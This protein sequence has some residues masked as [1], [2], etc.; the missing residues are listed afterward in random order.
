M[1]ILHELLIVITF[2]VLLLGTLFIFHTY[3]SH[4]KVI[5]K[6]KCK[7]GKHVFLSDGGSCEK[8]RKTAVELMDKGEL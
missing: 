3:K 5:K 7:R 1:K 6:K 2:C 4:I 8:C